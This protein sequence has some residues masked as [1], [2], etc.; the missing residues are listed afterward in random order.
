[1]EFNKHVVCARIRGKRSEQG[2]S[3]QELADKA[4]VSLDAI[5]NYENDE[6]YLPSAKAIASLCNALDVTPNYLLGW[7]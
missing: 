2:M 5:H 4:G 3:Q 7:D 1:M 6:G